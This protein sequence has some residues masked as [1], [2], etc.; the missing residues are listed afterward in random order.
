MDVAVK[1][2]FKL[3]DEDMQEKF[4]KIEDVINKTIFDGKIQMWAMA[5]EFGVSGEY[6]YC[7]MLIKALLE[8]TNYVIK[9]ENEEVTEAYDSITKRYLRIRKVMENA[10]W[11]IQMGETGYIPYQHYEYVKNVKVT[12][13][14]LEL[15]TSIFEEYVK[16]PR[17]IY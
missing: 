3:P 2:T 16:N 7:A 4:T 10:V 5:G 1:K 12:T 17:G 14:T 6:E 13:P 11:P 8:I 15:V 9:L